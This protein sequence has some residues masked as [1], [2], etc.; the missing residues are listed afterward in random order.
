[1]ATRTKSR[2]SAAAIRLAETITGGRY[3]DGKLYALPRGRR[4]VKSLAALI[5]KETELPR[6]L[7]AC[8]EALDHYSGEHDQNHFDGFTEYGREPDADR[9]PECRWQEDVQKLLNRV[10]GNEDV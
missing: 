7:E 6:L 10:K 4:S 5:E 9:C 3:D 2:H 1:M 8:Q